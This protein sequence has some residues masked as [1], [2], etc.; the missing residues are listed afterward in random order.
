MG[1]AL[2]VIIP[3]IEGR[4]VFYGEDIEIHASIGDVLRSQEKYAE[5][6]DAYSKAIA[7]VGQPVERHWSLFYTRGISFDTRNAGDAFLLALLQD[8]N[9]AYAYLKVLAFA[10]GV[11]PLPAYL[12]L[13]RTAGKLAI[14]GKEYA[15]RDGDIMHFLVG[16]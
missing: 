7:L 6:A 3:Q 12:E 5:A 2:L 13:C 16:N 11:H 15:P 10:E 14:E 8:L 1:P 4:K 9:E